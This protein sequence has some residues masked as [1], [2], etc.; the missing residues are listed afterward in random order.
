MKLKHACTYL[1]TAII[2][3][4][5]LAASAQ[6]YSSQADRE[7]LSRVNQSLSRQNSPLLAVPDNQKI[8]AAQYTCTQLDNGRTLASLDDEIL[9]ASSKVDK[10]EEREAFVDFLVTTQIVG[11]YKYCPQHI[12]Q[13]KDNIEAN[14]QN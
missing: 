5:P 4:S 12:E 2:V 13:L 7:Y 11:I 9:G 8:A 6:T 1:F 3:S 14:R 10:R